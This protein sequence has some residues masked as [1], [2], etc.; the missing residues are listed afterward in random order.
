[1]RRSAIS[2]GNWRGR[3]PL[4]LVGG[5]LLLWQ[6]SNALM[7]RTLLNRLDY[8][9]YD[10][11][12][13]LAHHFSESLDGEEDPPALVTIVDIDEESL[14][15]HGRWPWSRRDLARL[16]DQLNSAGATVVAWD[17]VFSE[18]ERLSG[19]DLLR[20][21]DLEAPQLERLRE[22]AEQ[23]D[24]D[25]RLAEALD[26]GDHVLG[27]FLFLAEDR[28][29]GEL[30]PSVAT[31]PEQAVLPR[32]RGH[33]APLT[34]LQRSARGAGFVTTLPDADGVIRRTPLLIDRVG[35]AYPSLALAAALQYLLL[36]H[37][38]LQFERVGDIDSLAGLGLTDQPIWTDASGQVLI[39]YPPLAQRVPRI[40]AW[41]L[42]A[43]EDLTAELGGR[44]VLV[45]TS[46]IGLADLI[47]TPLTNV[48]PG[49]EVQALVARH[50][51]QGGF[52]VRPDWEP[53]ATL[54][55]QL[56]LL[57]VLATQLEG[58]S[59][60]GMT[61]LATGLLG[62]VLAL[63]LVAWSRYQLDLPVATSV[64][65]ILLL[66]IMGLLQGFLRES[67]RRQHLKSVFGQYVPPAHI[68]QMLD[69]PEAYTM[70]GESRE[71][72][73]LFSDIRSFTSISEQLS[74]SQL[75]ALL[76]EY[77]DPVTE[78]IFR[79]D[80][81]IDKY[82]GD[83][84]MAFWGAPIPDPEHRRKAII[85]A[86][87]M[88]TLT[89]DLSARLTARGL[90]EI[91]IGIG[92]NTGVMNVGDMGSRY[93][94]AYTVLGDAV[95]LGSRLEG[96]TKFYGVGILVGE[97]T[98]RG[99]GDHVFRFC[100][101]LQVKGKETAI[102]AW[103]PLGPQDQVDPT[104]QARVGRYHEAI[105]HYFRREWAAATALLETLAE[106]DP[107]CRVYALFLERTRA[108]A[109]EGVPPDWNGVW[110]HTSK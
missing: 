54:V 44:I 52:P 87:A 39:P 16:A 108:L 79:H 109:Q 60:L 91:R 95:N 63:N 83:M 1:M 49:V 4:W 96:L 13:A 2:S 3:W 66:Y 99:L 28:Q 27:Y 86:L 51:V 17:V 82:V 71:L 6:V 50:L 89:K 15:R 36:E 105:E 70:E 98:R 59:A 34:V 10:L 37:P 80:G 56:V 93:R 23:F 67:Q 45:G 72:T 61:L 73:V 74:A 11:R 32:A 40:P 14:A 22:L 57:I 38:D 100:D 62:L 78:L 88:Q 69:H 12:M 102:D 64:L 7:E 92:L 33:T 46:S 104:E 75:K 19:L 76:N 9:V 97:D 42:L 25:R 18:P 29:S 41:R 20:A 55:L 30:P 65:L 68:D 24:P 84:V 8:L 48:F 81:T 107:D 77:F 5:L 26:G 90:P 47:S 31:L 53:G 21:S 94:K 85:T 103:E 35:Q 101:R 58:R 106:E 43:G 110:R